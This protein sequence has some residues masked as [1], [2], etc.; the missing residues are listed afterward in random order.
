MVATGFNH[1]YSINA[2]V[3]GCE[4]EGEY[5]SKIV[6]DRDKTYLHIYTYIF[7]VMKHSAYLRRGAAGK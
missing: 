2:E 7:V 5:G 6:Y 4:S 1:K 3:R